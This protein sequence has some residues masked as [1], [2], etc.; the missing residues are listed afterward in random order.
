MIAERGCTNLALLGMRLP[1][2]PAAPAAVQVAQAPRPRMRF[3][4]AHAG[5]G[6]ATGT[7]QETVR[8]QVPAV[9]A[10]ILLFR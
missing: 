1:F 7:L 5:A 4:M 9:E 3:D 8:R 10:D 6:V 2:V